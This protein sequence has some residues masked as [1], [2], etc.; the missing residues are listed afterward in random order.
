[1]LLTTNTNKILLFGSSKNA[2]K[3][4]L[5]RAML[6]ST[7]GG[8]S[9]TGPIWQPHSGQAVYSKKTGTIIQTVGF[10]AHEQVGAGPSQCAIALHKYCDATVG[11]TTACLACEKAHAAEL[12]AAACTASK[13]SR[14][15]G[16]GPKPPTPPTPLNPNCTGC[17]QPWQLPPL[18]P[19]QLAKCQTGT[20]RSTDDGVTWSAPEIMRVNN[21]IGPAYGGGGLN[22][23]IEIQRGPFAG[24]LALARRFNCKAVMGDHNEQQYFHSFVLYSDDDGA[25]W[26]MGELLPKGWTECQVFV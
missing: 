22:H 5:T 19:Q 21:S 7:D 12:K 10:P 4:N 26:T 1:M 6:T 9:W 16:A 3:T 23:G 13:T 20:V 8:A 25:S 2:V 17:L 24:R 15:C 18:T 11:N 14:F